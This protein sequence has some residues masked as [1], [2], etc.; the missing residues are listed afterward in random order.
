ML[1]NSTRGE[2]IVRG[3]INQKGRT[4]SL[5]HIAWIAA[6][7]S[8]LKKQPDVNRF[9]SLE[10]LPAK[11][12]DRGKLKL[13]ESDEIVSL[14]QKLLAIAVVY[15]IKAKDLANQLKS[16]QGTE[17]DSRVVETFAVPAAIVSCAVGH[18]Q[19][20][21]KDLLLSL[22]RIVDKLDQGETDPWDLF[23]DL[24]DSQVYCGVN[25]GMLTVGQ[26]L[27]SPSLFNDYNSRL[28]AAGIL[29]GDSY[30]FVSHNQV[31]RVLL[32]DSK[33]KGQR[34]DTLLLR[35][36]GARKIRKRIASKNLR[37]IEIPWEEEA[38]VDNDF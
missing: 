34:I 17:V 30:L 4:Y 7:E 10:L 20:Q 38:V 15:A 33:W 5:R 22:L 3:T 16:T 25:D 11:E 24:I 1:R 27:D 32:K 28:E 6:I 2:T 29:K 12:K 18:S 37:G 14:G 23:S 19:E 31:E 9:I 13:L 21:A 35:I 36:K 26:I 8:G